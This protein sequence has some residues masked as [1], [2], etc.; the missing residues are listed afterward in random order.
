MKHK[1]NEENWRVLK[2]YG[3]S[4]CGLICMYNWNTKK[5]KKKRKERR[6]YTQR[7]FEDIEENGIHIEKPEESEEDSYHNWSQWFHW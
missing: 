1:E 4:S 7:K 3:I 6:N 2:I 5:K